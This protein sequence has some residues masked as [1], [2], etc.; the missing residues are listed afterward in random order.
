MPL[1]SLLKLVE[2]L[3]D[4]IDEHGNTLRQSEALTRYALIDPLLRELGWDTADPAL[5][6]PEYRSGVGSSDYALLANG[7]PMM[8]V[9]AKKLGTQ[10]QDAVVQGIQYCLMEGT[11]YFTLTDGE[12]WEIYRIQGGVPIADQRIVVVDLRSQSLAEACL[13]ALALWRP[14]VQTGYV[15]AGSEL[16]PKKTGSALREVQEDTHARATATPIADVTMSTGRDPSDED[17]QSISLV[18]PEFKT[19][20][21]E[22]MFPDGTQKLIKSWK[23]MLVEIVEWLIK[24]N[25]LTPDRCPIPFSDRSKRY[26]VALSPSHEDGS[27]F[28]ET[29]RVGI[30]SFHV[31][32]K[33]SAPQIV[34]PTRAL[35]E[36]V[37]QDP[38]QFKV[39]Y[40]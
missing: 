15:G 39:K 30:G 31:D 14:S 40:R 12:R 37:G 2:T 4:R 33:H 34:R 20:P 10:L 24:T 36:H 35:I 23:A 38:A 3:R 1:E 7:K 22:L 28:E 6:I 19:K 32:T 18:A 13:R 5:V 29:G 9:E 16:V 26:V 11:P 17:W 25:H 21:T 27:P 8:M